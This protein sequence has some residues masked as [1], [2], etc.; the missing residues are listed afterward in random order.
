MSIE[1]LLV[2]LLV[3][4]IAGWLAG[5]VTR[6]SGYGII[7]DIIVGLLGALIGS[8]LFGLANV[9]LHLGNAIVERIA[10]ALI[11]AVVLLLIVS[12]LRPR[13]FR[14]RFASFWRR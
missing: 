11:G 7:G 14:E 4:A 9:S 5:L 10:V 8:W 12:M 3:G 6:G 2:T 13:R 1:S